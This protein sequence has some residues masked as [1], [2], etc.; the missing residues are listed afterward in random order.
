[1]NSKRKQN[2]GIGQ[3]NLICGILILLVSLNDF[4]VSFGE[5]SSLISKARNISGKFS[6]RRCCDGNTHHKSTNI[7]RWG[8]KRRGDFDEMYH[9]SKEKY[10]TTN[11]SRRE[12]FKHSLVG[13]IILLSSSNV[14]VHSPSIANA[15]CLSGDTSEDCIGIYKLPLD[16][17]ILPFIESKEKLAKY[18]PD[19][20]WV[21]P[22]AYP[23][24]YATAKVEL[25]S[26]T[27][28]IQKVQDY[29][30]K[31]DLKTAGTELLYI[32]PRVT[33]AGRVIIDK[34]NK[35]DQK[36]DSSNNISMKSLRVQ[37]AHTEFLAKLGECDVL[38]GQALR[39]EL[40]AI[41]P[42]QIQILAILK[43]MNN[44]YNDLIKTLSS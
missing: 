21:P 22:V 1:M 14:L 44:D 42:A 33:V 28:R 9:D 41:T 16:D 37:A 27:E 30:L 39:G 36:N 8:A 18:A 32:G 40:G 6:S 34:L 31:G 11:L 23:K 5:F 38:I 2:Y 3:I 7:N 17:E 15:A 35:D 29:V 10:S 4:A 12:W 26:F 19:L 13:G 43:D 20:R 25:D 24:D